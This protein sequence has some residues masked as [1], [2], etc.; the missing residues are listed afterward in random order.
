[1][2]VISVN[3]GTATRLGNEL[4]G[5]C[6]ESQVAPIEIG[7]LGLVGDVVCDE[8]FHGGLDQAV[9]VYG[10]EDYAYWLTAHGLHLAPGTFGDNI[11]ISELSSLS[12][13]VGDRL[14]INDVVLEVTAPRIPCATLGRRMDDPKFPAVFRKSQR[15]GFYCRVLHEGIVQQDSEVELTQTT[16]TVRLAIVDMFELYY[17]PSPTKQKLEAALQ[18]PIATRDRERL[19]KRLEKQYG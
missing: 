1:M 7:K 13:Y 10:G 6:K 18:T 11:T 17:D 12:V 15:S 3:V 8:Q 16:N 2:N 9:Y 14:R 5:I 4:T 19:M